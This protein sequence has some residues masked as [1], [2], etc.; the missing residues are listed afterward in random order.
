MWSNIHTH[1]S[2]CD[3]KSSPDEIV[4]RAETLGL[5]SLG[6]AS[7]GPLPFPCKWC[8]QPGTLNDYLSEISHLKKT[9]GI[10]VF[11][12]LEVDYIPG[13]IGPADLADQLDFTIGSVHF[14]DGEGDFRWEADTNLMMFKEGLER[15]FRGDVKRAVIRYFTLMREM[16]R[17]STPDVLG[18][19]DRIKMHNTQEFFFDETESWYRD[20]VSATIELAREKGVIIEV[21]TRGLYKKR[22]RESYPGSFGLSRIAELKIPVMLASDAH[23]QDDLILFFPE[24][25]AQ[26]RQA[27][28][29]TL[30]HLTENGWEEV[31]L[32]SDFN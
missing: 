3:G 25:A 18:H 26:L 29:R 10:P 28:I 14:V 4:R 15:V 22:S 24:V 27:G 1:S 21:N 31:P 8:I 30:I 11:A 5:A 20:E 12:G 32:P 7:H 9:A 17:T 23:H 19:M 13:I 16:L 6:F 2:W